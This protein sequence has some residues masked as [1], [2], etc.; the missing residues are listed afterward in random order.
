MSVLVETIESTSTM[1]A[2]EM[3]ILLTVSKSVGIFHGPK[4]NGT[5]WRL[6]RSGFKSGFPL[7]GC[8]GCIDSTHIPIKGPR[9]QENA[10]VNCKGYHSIVLQ[11]ICNHQRKFTDVFCGCAGSTHDATVL[12]SS[13]LYT[14]VC[15]NKQKYLPDET[16]LIGDKAYPLESWLIKKYQD[17]GK[18]FD[19]QARFNK[20]LS[21]KRQLIEQTFCILKGRF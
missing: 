15:R 12:R 4:A 14:E 16:Y 1:S 18:L 3:E 7:Q 2:L 6:V 21:N 8:I 17:T 5:C 10:Y 20:R 9:E 19:K 13:P 11:G